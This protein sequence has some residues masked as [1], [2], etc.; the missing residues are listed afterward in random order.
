MTFTAE[1]IQTFLT[2]YRPS[3]DDP[4][5]G[6]RPAAVL[7][8]FYPEPDGLSLI[9]TKRTDHL[10]QHSGQIS[11]PGGMQDPEDQNPA[12]TALRETYEEIGVQPEHIQLW[13]RLNQEA[14][15]T[16]ISVAPFVGRIQYPVDF[17]L[18]TDEVERLIIVPL[19]HL[20][21][22]RYFGREFYD[23]NG[24]QY[25]TYTYTYKGDV[26][27]GATARMVHNLLTLL[28][29]GREPE[30]P[31]YYRLAGRSLRPD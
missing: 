10:E 17:K 19:A 9:F 6:L 29:T 21:D 18:N 30:E 20:L 25:K 28:A 16:G 27:W 22:P 12:Q 14:T 23:I 13:G 3:T 26:I 5:P 31:A 24:A 2:E 11:F 8:P 4:A 15:V 7:A 1:H